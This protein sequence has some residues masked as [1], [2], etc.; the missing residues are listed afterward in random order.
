MRLLMF[1]LRLTAAFIAWAT[2]SALVIVI[3]A[4]VTRGHSPAALVIGGPLL[5]L[6]VGAITGTIAWRTSRSHPAQTAAFIA[7]LLAAFAMASVVGGA[8]AKG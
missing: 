3:D 6:C 5:A 8:A 1:P 4:G 2:G 7:L